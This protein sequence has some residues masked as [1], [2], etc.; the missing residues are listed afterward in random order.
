MKCE[1]SEK[2]KCIIFTLLLGERRKYAVKMEFA[3]FRD[4]CKLLA[5]KI[6]SDVNLYIIFPSIDVDDH[7]LM[8][9]G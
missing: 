9:C 5:V 2:V 7:A 4:L 1:V 3:T 8:N 6:M